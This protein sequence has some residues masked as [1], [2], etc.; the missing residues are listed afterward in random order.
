MRIFNSSFLMAVAVMS[1]A[2]AASLCAQDRTAT[3]DSSAA[4]N[5]PQQKIGGDDLLVMRVYDSPEF[6]RSLR[7]S[8]D[9]TIRIPMIKEPVNVQGLFPSQVETLLAD[10]LQREKL[11]VDPF[12][13]V[14]VA[15]YHSRPISVAGAVKAPLTFQAIGTVTLLEALTR[16]GGVSELAGPE[17]IVTRAN[18]TSGAQSVQR[19]PVKPLIEGSDSELNLKL[20]GGEEVR[21]PEVG[22][23][24][25]SG[26]VI[27]PGILPVLDSI[28]KNTVTTVI[29][30]AGGLAPYADHTAYILRVDD[31][32]VTHT[33]TVPLWEIINR[34]KPD[35]TLQ[36]KDILQVPDSPKRRITQTAIQTLTGVGAAATT[37]LVITRR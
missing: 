25:V 4:V 36:A 3:A 37:G 26:S 21:I 34:R 22:R 7:V 20:V 35:M 10:L 9:G 8:P 31:Q 15:E 1:A 19:I 18:G 11:L 30:Q 28:A 16:A 33:I 23:I 5:L 24:V 6:S 14:T 12:V 29:A 32:G 2:G 13:T 17:I 27:R